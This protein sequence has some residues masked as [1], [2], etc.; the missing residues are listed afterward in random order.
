MEAERGVGP[1]RD[2]DEVGGRGMERR[3]AP[4]PEWQPDRERQAGQEEGV[5]VTRGRF[6]QG[7]ARRPASHRQE[8]VPVIPGPE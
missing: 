3:R 2:G 5:R 4:E 8:P 1:P 6:W 7:L